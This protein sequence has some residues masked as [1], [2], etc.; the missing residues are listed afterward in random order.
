[1]TVSGP[2]Q[3][4]CGLL[5]VAASAGTIVTY[6]DGGCASAAGGLQSTATA[7][8]GAGTYAGQQLVSGTVTCYNAANKNDAAALGPS[9]AAWLVWPAVIGRRAGDERA[10]VVRERGE[11]ERE[12]RQVAQSHGWMQRGVV[13]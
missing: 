11:S 4:P 5:G 7:K 3:L 13:C 2:G 1:M 10:A 12:R 6:S 8:C 9:S